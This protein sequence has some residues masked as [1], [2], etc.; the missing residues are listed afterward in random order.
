MEEKIR[1]LKELL[2]EH[3]HN[4]KIQYTDE[5]T[6][7]YNTNLRDNDIIKELDDLAD[8]LFITSNG[9]PNYDAIN[10][11]KK[12]GIYV[13]PGDKDSFGWLTG[14]VKLYGQNHAILVFG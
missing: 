13:F 4:K 3:D 8:D 7:Y 5:G 9:H 2:I 10:M 1:R 6:R 11:A 14:C 12:E